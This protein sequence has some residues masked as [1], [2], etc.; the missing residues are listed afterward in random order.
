MLFFSPQVIQNILDNE[1]DY[2]KELQ[3]LLSTYLRS[4]QANDKLVYQVLLCPGHL[5]STIHHSK[6][7]CT[8]TKY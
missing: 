3:V 2:A 4:L 1:H 6:V 7:T 5:H 8:G